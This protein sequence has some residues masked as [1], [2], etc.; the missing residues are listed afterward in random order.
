MIRADRTA[1][2]AF[3]NLLAPLPLLLAGW[4]PFWTGALLAGVSG[5]PLRP[6]ALLAGTVG[7]A[8]LVLAAGVAR[9]TF[10]SGS[11]RYPAW[12]LGLNVAPMKEW[13]AEDRRPTSRLAYAALGLAAVLG[14]LLQ[15]LGRTGDLTIPLGALGVLGGYFAFAP[16]L[17]WQRRG[18][19]EVAF[20]LCFG[21]L[22]VVAGFYLQTGYWVAE[23]L[24]YALPLT[25][26]GF[27]LFLV[28]GFPDPGEEAPP[29]HSLAAR[30]GP[31]TAALIYTGANVLTIVILLAL[32][33]FP[34]SPL[35]WRNGLWPLL[36]LAV[37]N[38]E[39][40]KR[41]AYQKAARLAW[42]CRLSLA[43]HLGM[44]VVF[45]L[46]LWQRL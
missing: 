32:L 39:L 29:R 34:A 44:G 15:F 14:V 35:P 8:A 7:L 17:A 24:F 3:E 20:A 31:A 21:L 2:V 5:Y 16:P 12:R 27:N 37:V 33:F 11:G 13:V 26:A 10:A 18:L 36:A 4:L 42:L 1:A 46:M 19:G 25:L 40:I 43:Q 6:G 22:P 28:Y 23:E 30:L 9:E 41:R 38:Q 45:C